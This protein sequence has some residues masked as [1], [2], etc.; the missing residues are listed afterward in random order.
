MLV[1]KNNV[2]KSSNVEDS[3]TSTL[4]LTFTGIGE[5]SFEYLVSSEDIFDV[6]LISVNDEVYVEEG[7]LGQWTTFSWYSDNS[8]SEN[9]I[10]V[11]YRK[12]DNTSRR[13]NITKM[14]NNNE[15]KNT[16][17]DNNEMDMEIKTGWLF[18]NQRRQ[19][20]LQDGA[21]TSPFGKARH[22]R[23]HDLH[24][25]DHSDA[26]LLSALYYHKDFITR[27]EIY[28]KA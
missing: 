16:R 10:T 19:E 3:T 24:I 8:E 22:K 13:K 9:I 2:I 1:I 17:E 20:D 23:E 12:D 28:K 21:D 5:I 6:I 15:N 27:Y 11:K 18:Q 26:A 7:G 25:R 4:T 14:I